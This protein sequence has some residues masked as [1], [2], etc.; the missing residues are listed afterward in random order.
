M[1]QEPDPARRS[2][3]DGR[4]RR[5]F[6]QDMDKRQKD[7]HETKMEELRIRHQEIDLRKAEMEFK[8][9]EMLLELERLKQQRLQ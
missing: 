1:N 5:Q 8:R 2:H 3:R 4:K 7:D 9:T 6:H